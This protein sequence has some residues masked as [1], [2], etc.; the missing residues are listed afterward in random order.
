MSRKRAPVP[1]SRKTAR[2]IKEVAKRWGVEAGRRLPPAFQAHMSV[3][4]RE[5][6]LAMASLWEETLR[7]VE[8]GARRL[9]RSAERSQPG[10]AGRRPSRKAARRRRP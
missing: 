2:L 7:G 1:V 6:L 8:A 4:I 3:S 9:R 10:V 5:G